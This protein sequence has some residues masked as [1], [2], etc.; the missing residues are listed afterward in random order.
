MESFVGKIVEINDKEGL[1]LV[2]KEKMADNSLF[3]QTFIRDYWLYPYD[4][5][6]SDDLLVELDETIK[7]E[8]RGLTF[9]T[10]KERKDKKSY[11]VYGTSNIRGV[12]KIYLERIWDNFP[13]R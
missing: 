7:F 13:T 4:S 12:E 8:L 5:S 9:N 6:L 10:V 3:S 2:V 1:F 11:T